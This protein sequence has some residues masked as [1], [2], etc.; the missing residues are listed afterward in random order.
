MG[1]FMKPDIKLKSIYDLDPVMLKS[2][3]IKGLL[4]DIDNTL[5][6]Y[7]TIVPSEKLIKFIKMISDCG[8]KIGIISNAKI[9]RSQIFAEGFPKE[10]YPMIYITGKAQ[11]PL[12]KGFVEITEQ[13]GIYLHEAAMIG[14]QLYT[15]IL[16]GN[17]A[18]CL[19]ILVNPININIEPS[20]VKFKRF[21]EKPFL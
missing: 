17:R 3:G 4:F 10:E 2:K 13:M 11:K 5:E 14:D 7:A 19:T 1:S 20:F 16:G 21:F 18:G 8:F 6:E 15:D 9:K 12:K